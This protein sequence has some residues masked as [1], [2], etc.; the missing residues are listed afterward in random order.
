MSAKVVLSTGTVVN[1]KT[2]D[3]AGLCKA[4]NCPADPVDFQCPKTWYRGRD[5]RTINRDTADLFQKN[6]M[7]RA[8]DTILNLPPLE[9]EVVDYSVQLEPEAILEYNSVLADA[10]NLRLRIE[11]NGA[12]T[13]KDLQRLMALLQL[14][15]QMTIHPLLAEMG[16]ARFKSERE[17]FDKAAAAPTGAMWA[18]KQ[19]IDQLR[20][21]GHQ[22]VVVACCHTSILEIARRF[23]VQY[24][25]LGACDTFSG[26]LSTKQRHLVK[27]RFLKSPNAVLMLSIGA[28]GVGLHLVPGCE[29]MIFWGSMPFSPA[30]TRQCMKRI[31]RI[32][33]HAPITG[34][35]SIKHLVPY[36]SVDAAIG[37]A[38]ADKD[39][40][41]AFVQEGD[42]SGFKDADD[43]TWRKYGRIVDEC[44]GIEENG[45]FPVMPV[46]DADD[47]L[48]QYGY[49]ILKGI[50]TRNRGAPKPISTKRERE[51]AETGIE[52]QAKRLKNMLAAIGPLPPMP[53]PGQ[54]DFMAMQ[55][56]MLAEGKQ[57]P[58]P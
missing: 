17:L 41:I 53:V 28:G 14:M 6:Y 10:K 36:G 16:A 21:C 26:E 13:G 12:A 15:Q 46:F 50:Q 30:Q 52:L 54:R 18:L 9:Q 22:R 39:R 23:L 49:A 57:L 11:R 38:H 45:T 31:H 8:S 44:Q 51:E 19:E 24:P 35:V 7:N 20:E 58:H 27:E 33:Q 40:L 37:K 1:N 29:A 5:A 3:I 32:G 56:H 2:L 47:A 25:E 34:R 48:G 43:A 4:G 42:D 55:M